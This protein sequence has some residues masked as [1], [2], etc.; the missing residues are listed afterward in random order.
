MLKN[1]ILIF[2]FTCS[3]VFGQQ[4]LTTTIESDYLETSRDVRIYIPKS[5]ELDSVK[6][7]PLAIVFDAEFLFDIYVGNSVL[8]ASKDKAP[9]Q[10]V[11]G[12]NMA[13]TRKND[14]YFNINT[15]KLNS[16]NRAFYEF[17]RDEVTFYMESNY[18]TS[19]FIS[20][21]GTGTSANL[22]S[23]FLKEP[24]PVFNAYVCINPIFSDFIRKQ[25][26]DF[27]LE[28]YG[29]EDNTFYLYTNNSNTFSPKRQT[30]I[31]QLQTFLGN[32]EIE[33]FNIV[34]DYITTKSSISTIGEAIPRAITKV[35]ELYSAI[36]KD[37][38]DNKIKNLSPGDAIAYL[39]NKYIEIE[40]LFG[41]NLG[42]R[43]QDVFT[44]ES[45]I[46]DKENGDYLR[47]F[48]KMILK[49]FPSSPLGD[50]YIGR[51]YEEG[52]MIKK[53]LKHYKIGY[54]KM[55]PSDPNADKFYENILRLG[56]Q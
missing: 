50:Y 13:E 23:Q 19:P 36:S 28:R 33:N 49:L 3:S 14:T 1:A 10:I 43:E 31:N 48:G 52:K 56:G 17:I 39:E 54:G 53:A 2:L 29:N 51:Y 16:K 18:R 22:I 47:D 24:K 12:I 8:F 25:M 21:I 5:Y 34:N 44:I 35:F 15:G 30:L 26:Q 40:F 9:E 41:S 7:Y 27:A 45:I 32:Y 4:I 42:I 55:D 46:I 37:E 20:L 38:F 11:V 6:N